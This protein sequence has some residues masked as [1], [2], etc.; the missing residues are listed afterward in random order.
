MLGLELPLLA[1]WIAL[2]GTLSAVTERVAD[3]NDMTD[4][5]VWERLAVSVGQAHSILPTLHGQVIRSLSQLYPLLVSPFFRHGD[6]PA[7]IRGAHISNAWLMTSAAIPAFLLARRVTGRRW[8]GYVLAFVAVCTPWLVYST[9][10]L[11]EVA[12]YPAFIW[13]AFGMHRTLTAPSKRN[14]AIALLT[15]G[16]AFFARTQFAVLLA[17]LPTALVL[18]AVPARAPRRIGSAVWSAARAHGVLAVAYGVLALAA[19]AYLAGGHR[20]DQLTVYGKES[21]PKVLTTMT[22]EAM[23]GHAADLAF[24]LGVLPF[25]VGVG[26]LL[27]NA[28]RPPSSPA[29]HAFACLG[30]ATLAVLLTIVSAWDLTLGTFVFDRYLF[31]L[32]PLVVLAFLCALR[33]RRRPGWAL[34]I[35]AAVVSYGFA[36]HLQESFLWS[37]QFPLSFDSPISQPYRLLEGLGG[38]RTALSAILVIGTLA[39]TGLFVVASRLVPRAALTAGLT[40]VLVVAALGDTAFTFAKLFSMP[41]H[42]GRSLTQSESGTLDWL[43][44][45]VGAGAKVTAVPYSVSSTFRFSQQTWR[46]LEFWNKSLRYDVHYPTPAVFDDAVIW[47]PN[48]PLA[49]NP[50]TGAASASLSPYVVQS[51]NETRFRI[52]GN[53]QV[54]HA[55]LMLIDAKMPWRTD[56]LT[57]G[58]Y[59]DGWTQPK[60]AVRIRV[61][62]VPGQASAVTRTLSIQIQAPD[63]IPRAP[64]TLASNLATIHATV[65]NTATAFETLSICVPARGYAEATLSTPLVAAIPSDESSAPGSIAPREGGIDL[66]D[67]SLSDDVGTRCTA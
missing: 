54:V 38:G 40:A 6:V 11:T 34:L 41:G 58:L 51:L 31:Y 17:V 12:A 63:E 25:V 53:E 49:F 4:E 30:A 23:T 52:S 28:F 15:L 33:D 3:W 36:A 64:F 22:A 60:M 26:W 1:L 66:A 7:D 42:S 46:D 5:L 55:N 67:L 21:Q 29:A 24:A 14:D 37:T 20:L 48:T 62:S 61:F 8:P 44:L 47:F 10:I 65:T 59:E 32:V 9:A 16:L 57:S 13:A 18:Y 45:A 2:A 56:W 50:R 39:V 43:D 19:A 27:A 35:P